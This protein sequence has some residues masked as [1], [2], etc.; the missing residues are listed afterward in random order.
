MTTARQSRW[1][2]VGIAA[3]GIGVLATFVGSVAG[4]VVLAAF[5]AF[6][7]G[8]HFMRAAPAMALYSLFF[9]PMFAWPTAFIVL[10]ITWVAIPDR[11]VWKRWA[12]AGIG[13]LSGMITMF[14]MMELGRK[15]EG[16]DWYL[17]TCAA[18]GG[19]VA[20]VIFGCFPRLGKN[21]DSWGFGT[22]GGRESDGLKRK[23]L[24]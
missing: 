1:W 24:L 21:R 17:P 10:P 22:A 4:A 5:G 11:V 3:L 23:R 13:A 20:G 16:A 8:I 7:E 9:G 2:R 18:M 14:A 12:L 6:H 15:P 19:V